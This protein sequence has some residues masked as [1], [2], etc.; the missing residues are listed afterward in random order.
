[1][2]KNF[3]KVALPDV[4]VSLGAM[5]IVLLFHVIIM[6]QLAVLLVTPTILHLM[7]V[8]MTTK[9]VVNTLLLKG[10][11]IV[12]FRLKQNIYHAPILLQLVSVK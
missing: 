6:D 12:N 9:D 10:V 11:Q 3:Y 4:H 5:Q 2:E 8:D 1:M 7:D